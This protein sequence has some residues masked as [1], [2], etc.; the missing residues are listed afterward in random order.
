MM[1][2]DEMTGS[3]LEQLRQQL[4]HRVAQGEDLDEDLTAVEDRLDRLRRHREREQL[5]EVEATRVAEAEAARSREDE[6]VRKAVHFQAAL[7]GQMIAAAEIEKA[8][9]QLVGALAPYLECG[10]KA[11]TACQGRRRRVL[12]A[13]QAATYL[14]WRLSVLLPGHFTRP[15]HALRRPLREALGDQATV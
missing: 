15:A 10:H 13:E 7:G 8:V 14:H 9:E 4:A 12:G 3:Q 6:A 2:L 11:Y 1:Y 5:A